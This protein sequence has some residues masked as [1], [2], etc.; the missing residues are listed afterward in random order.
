MT[1]ALDSE[2]TWDS[3]LGI[4]GGHLLQ[5]WNWGELKRR[6]CWTPERITVCDGGGLAMAQVLFRHMGPVSIGYV[7]RGPM[8]RGDCPSLWPRLRARIDEVARRHRAMSVILEPD[9][10]LDFASNGKD[11]GM[12]SG[13]VHIQPARTVK[14]P[15]IDDDALLGQMHQKTRYNVRLASRRGV[16][17]GA[18]EATGDHL[19]AVYELM[20]DTARR[21]EFGIH[22]INYYRDVLEA[23]G[24]NGVLLG[25]WSPE[26]GLAAGLIAARFGDE[27]IYLYGASSTEHRSHGAGVALQFEAMKWAREHG[28]TVY[29]L[30]GI[31]AVDPDTVTN[32]IADK[33]AGSKG[34]DW[35]GLYRF[36][37]GFG[38]EKVTYP[39][40]LERRYLPGLPWLARR[41]GVVHE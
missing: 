2:D 14:V 32:D 19:S 1:Q 21:N 24:D 3:Q 12:V 4:N 38:G 28:A 11:S 27:V 30:W 9:V 17:F 29:D 22:A 40:T 33:I 16:T 20:R 39:Q 34:K 41:L 26:G 13:P 37:T 31:P 35:R 6:H 25:A 5:S 10:P 7:P 8:I 15:L 23:L 36:K 18:M